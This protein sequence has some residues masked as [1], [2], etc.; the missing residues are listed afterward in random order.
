MELYQTTLLGI[1]QGLTEFLPVSSSA[2]LVFL[3]RLL[4]FREP[5][6]FLDISLHLGTLIAVAVFLRKELFS[7]LKALSFLKGSPAS[8]KLLD[9]YKQELP[10]RLLVLVVVSTFVTTV[11]ALLFKDQLEAAFSSLEVVAVSLMITGFI[12]W[13]TR[14][15]SRKQYELREMGFFKAAVIGLAQAVAITPGISRSGSTIACGLYLGMERGLA[16]RF[17]F[18]LSIPAILGA[19][20]LQFDMGQ[21]N[22]QFAPIAVGVCVSAL[23]GFVALKVLVRLVLGGRLWV[24]APYCWALGLTVLAGTLAKW[25]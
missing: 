8:W 11:L 4:G 16:A 20:I 21:I 1:V 23:T 13:G 2:H 18:L 19:A 12:I 15:A 9:R 3:Q 10:F 24:F 7:I 6:L 14:S 25:F 22:G 5:E 17:S